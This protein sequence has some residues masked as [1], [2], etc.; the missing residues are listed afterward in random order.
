MKKL[1]GTF[2][3]LFHP[4][5]IPFFTT[6]GYYW[7]TRFM[8]HPQEIYISLFQVAV[9]TIFLPMTIYLFL[10]SIGLL[11]SSI[12]VHHVRERLAPI[13]LNIVLIG[14]LIFIIFENNSNLALKRFFVALS[15]SYILLFV[16]VWMR[17]KWSI[18]MM[19]IAAMAT[20]LIFNA[21]FLNYHPL[22]ISIFSI[23]LS[24]ALATSRLALYAHTPSE[25]VSG[26]LVG[27][28]PQIL[29][30]YITLY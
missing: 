25:I 4:V 28:L 8:Y 6:F 12:M 26:S 29:M 13:F 5:L 2:S 30:F 15:T 20:F 19:N 16:T 23:L 14:I 10:K 27:L 9:M 18:H 1:F 21:M 7:M 24:G 22:E 3:Y 17:K 11:K